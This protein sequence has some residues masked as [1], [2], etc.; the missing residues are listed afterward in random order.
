MNEETKFH[1]A[2]GMKYVL[3]GLKALFLLNGAASISLLTFIGNTKSNS[4]SFVYAMMCF[5]VGSVMGPI[6]FLLA[7]LTQ[8]QYGNA[9]L[10]GEPFKVA[11]RFHFGTYAVVVLGLAS[12]IVGMY[13]AGEGF[14]NLKLGPVP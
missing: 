12:F 14:M 5:A 9:A 1:W 4:S 8:L 7:Y 3:E 10:K 2:E 6:A 13:F 11:S